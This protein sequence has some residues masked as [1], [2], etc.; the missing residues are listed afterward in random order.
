E[1][2]DLYGD[3]VNIASRL[4]ALADPGGILVS[5]TAY[6][7]VKSKITAEFD[8]LGLQTLKNMPE[9]VRTYRVAGTL[10]TTS[11]TA[12]QPSTKP[13]IAVLP[14]A[15][16]S[17]DPEQRYFSDGITEDIITELSR[18]RQLHVLARNASFRHRGKDLDITRVGR[19]LNAQYLVEG[20]VR[21]LGER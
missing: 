1:E 21:R 8:D 19:E 15:N 3:D 9:P 20:S 5:G 14:F 10:R 17:G 16:M 13:S 12:E 4:E 18:F 6:D 7:Q 11:R 2:G